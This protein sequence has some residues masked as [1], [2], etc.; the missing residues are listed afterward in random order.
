MAGRRQ[1]ASLEGPFDLTF[2]A[3]GN[4]LITDL[5]TN[6]IREVLTT[7]PAVQANP[8][9]LAFTAPAGSRGVQQTI[10]VTGSIPNFVFGATVAS[11]S[12]W[13][14]V[15]PHRGECARRD[16]SDGRSIGARAWTV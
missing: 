4:L 1:Q 11:G 8:A 9:S 15:T 6:R 16:S 12:S 13:L 2:D 10:S 3:G 5:Y 7:S 14:S